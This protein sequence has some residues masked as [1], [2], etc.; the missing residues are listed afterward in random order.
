MVATRGLNRSGR[1]GLNTTKLT[2]E[3]SS[4]FSRPP[5][6]TANPSPVKIP[7]SPQP[8]PSPHQTD[9]QP[10]TAG[11]QNPP[12]SCHWPASGNVLSVSTTRFSR[13]TINPSA[14]SGYPARYIAKSPAAT[15]GRGWKIQQSP[16]LRI[17]PTT[18]RTCSRNPS[19]NAH[20]PDP[21]APPATSSS[22]SSHCR[23]IA[24]CRISAHS[25]HPRATASRNGSTECFPHR[26]QIG[27]KTSPPPRGHSSSPSP[28]RAVLRPETGQTHSWLL[29]RS[30]L[31]WRISYY[32]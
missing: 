25:S 7:P 16:F 2:S 28:A 27:R 3:N 17:S 22:A 8:R 29:K 31:T 21:P 10:N 6:F 32:G 24:T 26:L 15:G 30:S 11:L 12:S 9:T 5:P 1:I 20:P 23:F 18:W 13:S 19:K 4:W 14:A